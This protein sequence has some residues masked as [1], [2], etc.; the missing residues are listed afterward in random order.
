MKAV[1]LAAGEG[2][3]LRPLTFTKSKHM[4]PIAGKPILEHLF[5]AL[6]D[7][8]ITETIVVV[9]HYQDLIQNRFKD[10]ERYGHRIRYI[11]QEK[12]LG[13]ANAI[14]LVEDHIDSDGFLIV[15]GDLQIDSSVIRSAIEKYNEKSLNVLSVV[16]AKNPQRYGV[17]TI[18]NGVVKDIVE[19]PRLETV[20]RHPVNAGVY[21]F[22]N[23]IFHEIKKTPK[24]KRGEYE[25]TDTI[26]H[27]LKR[28]VQVASN[29][30]SSESWTDIGYPWD[31]LEANRKILSREKPVIKGEIEDG[32]HVKG[33]LILEENAEIRSGTYIEGPVYIG[34]GSNVGPNC[35]IRPSTSIGNNAHVGNACEVKNSLIFDGT[36]IGH[37]SYV[38]DSIIGENCNLGAGTLTAN[39]RF[40]KRPV[41]VKVKDAL[42]DS[43]R[44]KLGAIIGDNVEVGIGVKIMPGIKVGPKSLIGPNVVLYRDLAPK[45]IVLQTQDLE[46]FK[47]K[48]QVQ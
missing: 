39:L 26:Q 24:S 37:L 43:G 44:K 27:L 28:N 35:H 42:I 25:I 41:K 38:G 23:R 16:Y 30:I 48:C 10:G 46:F 3:R 47:T 19:K 5:I 22:S 34:V 6:K 29:T 18:E 31:L 33:T 1:V 36:H 13:T 40:D 17:V 32:A 45:K 15:Y 8:G 11:R 2:T 20:S 4:I 14:S 12:L 9:N 21:V 7:A